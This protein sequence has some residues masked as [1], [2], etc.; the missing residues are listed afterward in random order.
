MR[1]RDMARFS[2][3]Y[4]PD[5]FVGWVGEQDGAIVGAVCIVFLDRPILCFEMTPGLRSERFLLH[6]WA[7]M[8][9]RAGLQACGELWTQQA[10]D[11]P[12]AER[13]LRRLGFLPTDEYRNGERLWHLSQ[14]QSQA[15]AQPPVEP[16]ALSA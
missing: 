13:W 10:S 4:L 11:E 6:R 9:I 7:K 2:R 15:S 3:Y 5:D 8:M 14:Q 1:Y 12:T 16:L